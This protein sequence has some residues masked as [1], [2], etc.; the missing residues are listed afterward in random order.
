MRFAALRD[1]AAATD[2]SS[3][4]GRHYTGRMAGQQAMGAGRAKK[5]EGAAVA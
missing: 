1:D 5:M 4:N 2:V 3:S